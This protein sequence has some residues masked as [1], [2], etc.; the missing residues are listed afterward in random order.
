[1]GA[2]LHIGDE[3]IEE[4]MYSVTCTFVNMS[5]GSVFVSVSSNFPIY[6]HQFFFPRLVL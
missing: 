4:I 5:F 1:M 2:K 3:E 6:E